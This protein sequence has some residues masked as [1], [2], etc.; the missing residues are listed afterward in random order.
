MRTVQ[1]TDT[2]VSI[3]FSRENAPSR[4]QM[5]SL[6]RQALVERG[7]DPWSSTEAECFAAGEDTLVIARPGQPHRLAFYF[8]ELETLLGGV[9]GCAE[10][11]SS[12]YAE[13]EGYILTAVPEAAGPALYEFGR[14]TPLSAAW[15]THG[16]EQGRLLIRDTAISDLRRYF[17]P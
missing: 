6:V 4:Q 14:E 15:E 11:E 12:L 8:E 3:W 13:G 1:A 10:G 7:L 9:M 16:E 5:L 2:A 17:S